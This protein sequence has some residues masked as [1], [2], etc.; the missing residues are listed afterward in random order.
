MKQF[1]LLVALIMVLATACTVEET[2]NYVQVRDGQFELEGKPYR[3]LGV[4]F[5]HGAYLA[6]DL[7]EGD[8][9]RLLEELDLLCENGITNLRV[10]ASAELSDMVASVKPAFQTEA[11]VYNEEMLSG[12]DLLLDEMGKRNMKAVMVMNNY[13]QWSGGM[14]QYKN[15]VSGEKLVDPDIDGYGGFMRQSATFYESMEAQEVYR[16][17]IDMLVHRTNTINGRLYKED[18]SIMAWQLANEP[19]PHPDALEKDELAHVFINWVDQTAGYIKSLDPNH[20]VSTGNEGSWGS[21]KSMDLY[22]N[23]HKTS[24]ID[25][26]TFHIWPKNWSWFDALN[27]E[28][29]FEQALNNTKSY[30]LDHREVALEMNKPLILEEFGMERDSGLFSPDATT[31]YRDSYL[32]EVFKMVADDVA[33]GGPLSGLNLWAWGGLVEGR[34]IKPKWEVGDSFTGDPPQE[35]QGLNSMFASDTS[36]LRI[37]KKYNE[38][39]SAR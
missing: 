13:W 31:T 34:N 30:F 16:G 27:P 25:Y 35:P 29:T 3:Y 18:P 12:L 20:L 2:E 24:N 38:I 6:A 37:F 1:Y 9:K 39:I 17:Y 32:S 33:A 5:W 8:R 23:A 11:G 36:T 10:S 21:L 15:W 28:A 19:R 22:I 4:N 7:V 14:A 26:L